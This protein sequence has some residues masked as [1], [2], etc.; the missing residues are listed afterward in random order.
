LN[1]IDKDRHRFAKSR[2]PSLPGFENL[3]PSDVSHSCSAARG[4]RADGVLSFGCNQL[5]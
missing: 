5:C 2:A 3:E 1:P 4:S